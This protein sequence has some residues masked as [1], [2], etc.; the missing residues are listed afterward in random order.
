MEQSELLKI[1]HDNTD[2]KGS[3]RRLV[4][5]LTSDGRNN[6]LPFIGAGV[7]KPFGFALWGDFLIEQGKISGVGARIEQLIDEKKYE[8]AAEAL[9]RTIGML[10]FKDAIENEFGLHKLEGTKLVGAV[11]YLPQ[12]TTGPVITTNFDRLLETVFDAVGSAFQ[13]KIWGAKADVVTESLA[14]NERLLLKLHGDVRDSADRILT[15]SDYNK[16]YLK[17]D[18]SDIDFE[19]PLPKLLRHLLTGRTLLFIGC[20]LE[21]D[22]TIE[23]LEQVA[24]DFSSTTHYAIVERPASSQD[25][26]RR[27]KFLSDRQI[28]PIWFPTKRYEIV[29]EIL[30]LLASK[31]NSQSSDRKFPDVSSRIDEKRKLAIMPEDMSDY[32]KYLLFQH[33]DVGYS[34]KGL[35]GVALPLDE[36]YVSLSTERKRQYTEEWSDQIEQSIAIQH[37]IEDARKLAQVA[38]MRYVETVGIATAIKESRLLVILGKPGSGKTTLTRFL[39]RQLARGYQDGHIDLIAQGSDGDKENYGPTKLPIYLRL[40][41]YATFRERTLGQKNLLAFLLSSLGNLP[42]EVISLVGQMVTQGKAFIFLDG[43]DE[44]IDPTI[45][46][47]I[48]QEILSFVNATHSENRC[49]V[50]SRIAGYKPLGGEFEAHTFT[51]R[52]MNP[53]QVKRF[54]ERFCI[55][56]EQKIADDELVPREPNAIREAGNQKCLA[57]IQ[58][59]EDSI[60][61]Q[62]LSEN[63]LTLSILAYVHRKKGYLPYSR[64]ALYESAIEIVCREWQE[65]KGIPASQRIHKEE[66]EYWLAPVAAWL[67]EYENTGFINY[68]D[69]VKKIED[70]G[71]LHS[72]NTSYLTTIQSKEFLERAAEQTGLFLDHAPLLYSPP[73]FLETGG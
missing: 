6:L 72:G 57:L 52:D 18:G 59:I 63:P 48:V 8:E 5:L 12:L 25:F 68:K 33:Q 3:L 50:T 67:H 37:G 49:L 40:A 35:F 7:S 34:G 28:R 31:V 61:L 62:R 44:V 56:H 36:I 27:R 9:L 19:K 39:T 15:K 66:L 69:I 43:L 17:N 45:R 22:R 29:E 10:A 70:I 54:L 24:S 58:A 23:V 26:A 38:R 71:A 16:H 47:S 60:S 42:S 1:L 11:S 53:A 64:S 21:N 30:A 51:L 32:I 73:P 14:K 55:A 4:E 2:N 20:S 46:T 41:E 65:T 13:E